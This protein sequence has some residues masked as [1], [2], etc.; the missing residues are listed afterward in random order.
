MKPY[1]K[2]VE[3]HNY[4]THKNTR[5]VFSPGINSIVGPNGAG[6]SN[7]VQAILFCLGER[8]PKNLRVSSFNEIV[9]NFR[10]DL[11]VSVTLTIVDSNGEEHRFKRIYSPRKGEHIYRYNGKRVSR[12]AY[13]LNLLKLGTNGLKHVYIKQGDI[14]RWADAT[15][16]DIKEMIHE[17]LGLKE[18]NQRRREALERLAEAEKKLESVQAQYLRMQEI[19][20]TFRDHMVSYETS[21]TATYLKN[22]LE[23]TITKMLL[24]EKEEQL[25]KLKKRKA[26]IDKIYTR[27]VRL[28]DQVSQKISD[29]I[30]KYSNATNRQTEIN[31]EINRLNTEIIKLLNEE[32][33]LRDKI[34]RAK[35]HEINTKIE[36]LKKEIKNLRDETKEEARTLREELQSLKTIEKEAEKLRK[37]IN[38]LDTKITELEKL[39]ED[40]IKQEAEKLEEYRRIISQES[41][42]LLREKIKELRKREYEEELRELRR[43]MEVYQRTI[44]ELRRRKEDTL[45]KLKSLR[46]ELERHRK[47]MRETERRLKKTSNEVS[48]AYK[49]LRKLENI[50]DNLTRDKQAEVKYYNDTS[51]VLEATK[52]LRLPGVYGILSEMVKGPPK[53]LRLIRDLDLRSWYAIIVK[54]RDT[55]LRVAEIANELEKDIS[56][57]TA[58]GATDKT[59]PDN[60]VIYL[61][62]YPK[63]IE[64]IVINLYGDIETVATLE[65]AL[66][67]TSKGAR[68]I[69]IDGEF[70]LHPRGYIRTT[71]IL[72]KLP[73][74]VETLKTI[75]DK[76]RRVIQRKEEE[77]AELEAKL[78]EQQ[79]EENKIMGRI[80]STQLTIKYIDRNI[81][82][83]S[84]IT[85]RLREKEK[86]IKGE[87]SSEK[88]ETKKEKERV[89]LTSQ[90]EEVRRQ[91]TELK[92]RRE[93]LKKELSKL[94][95]IINKKRVVIQL[96][97]N[98]TRAKKSRI[99][100]L[101]REIEALENE[102]PEL[103]NRIKELANQIKELVD[104][105]LQYTREINSLNKEL[106]KIKKSL[107]KL[108]EKR[109]KLEDRLSKIR[110]RR[111][112]VS[113]MR[114]KLTTKLS[115]L[116][117]EV[118]RLRN[119][120]EKTVAR[121]LEINNLQTAKELVDNLR[122]ELEEIGEVSQI[123]E[124]TFLE[125]LE[126]YKN[127]STRRSELLQ[128][129][130][131]ILEF[132]REIDEK[133][134]QIFEDGFQK[135]KKR[136]MEMFETVFPESK[137]WIE[138]E[139]EGNIDSGILVFIEFPG[140]PRITIAA[141]SG[142][143][144]TSIILMLLLSIYSINED[145]IFIFDEIDAHMDPRV[146]DNIARIIKAQEKYSQIILVTLPGHDSM[147]NIADIIIP[148][149]FTKG[150]SKAFSIKSELLVGARTP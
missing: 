127:Y 113:S 137:V 134:L 85:K 129:R 112:K 138:L 69:H 136:F 128:E 11:D 116:E 100:E 86:R 42:E 82:L 20:Y 50:L 114:T 143:E 25:A 53:I 110:E 18:Y 58:D 150:A 26:K 62:K 124:R 59:L 17:A 98:N 121:E 133:R 23:H 140:K 126:P 32:N 49:L 33:R 95:E 108:D 122:R 93:E 146:V 61:L 8:S 73:K 130:N 60:S 43:R 19:V 66:E 41:E 24:K 34:R 55:A 21:Q 71:G 139:E 10:K 80:I 76:F 36:L 148:V 38:N 125:Q 132:I 30:T 72:V 147:I 14:T 57:L 15:P 37:E 22:T 31:T 106:E 97:Q 107:K 101:K 52:T 123:A 68:T 104:K 77:L 103:K 63:K 48:N 45:N 44:N 135:I 75:R 74:D 120:L 118:T 105:R 111:E 79:R 12:T 88:R 131:E 16:K 149:T 144:R 87:L 47:S 117:A 92:N 39:E 78:R 51:K 91:I 142:G 99:Q 70:L 65:E 7:I 90:I 102:K 28:E 119:T 109:E 67:K 1:I 96:F 115:L 4:K 2:R 35:I 83:L 145:T 89:S 94:E 84:D 3:I 27:I 29:Y 5:L 13:L 6:K 46:E 54:D 56:I 141:A 64:N 40:I 81:K 9:Y